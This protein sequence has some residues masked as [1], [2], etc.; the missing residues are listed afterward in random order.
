MSGKREHDDGDGGKYRSAF[1]VPHKSVPIQCFLFVSSI[2][3]SS[4]NGDSSKRRGRIRF[5][6]SN[7]K[8]ER[9]NGQAFPSK[10]EVNA[11]IKAK[12]KKTKN[13][14]NG[15]SFPERLM[16]IMEHRD[17]WDAITWSSDGCAFGINPETFTEKVIDT[18]FKG[19]LFESM[20]KRFSRWGFQRVQMHMEFTGNWITYHHIL[21]RRGK[22]GLF[23]NLSSTEMLDVMAKSKE[24]SSAPVKKAA[25]SQLPARKEEPQTTPPTDNSQKLCTSPVLASALNNSSSLQ[26][27]LS[28]NFLH[29]QNLSR[30]NASD[31][32]PSSRPF[33]Q[34]SHHRPNLLALEQQQLLAFLQ[35]VAHPPM[36]RATTSNPFLALTRGHPLT[37]PQTEDERLLSLLFTSNNNNNSDV[38]DELRIAC[39]T[40][41]QLLEL[42]FRARQF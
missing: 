40:D 19:G 24:A 23:R 3:H 41:E 31:F 42:Y 4:G 14:T 9:E 34:D 28:M 35:Q 2:N 5:E 21:F 17:Y 29:S 12:D 33:L 1:F 30:L 16:Q 6:A 10:G 8:L 25:P 37:R 26:L 38:L 15:V 20:Q 13:D 36:A 39:L 7:P 11:V 27:P 22:P 18:H 32:S